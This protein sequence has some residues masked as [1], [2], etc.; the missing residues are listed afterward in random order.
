M[1]TIK[2]NISSPSQ[3]SSTVSNDYNIDPLSIFSK[4]I[5]RMC[6]G[7]VIPGDWILL[8]ALLKCLNNNVFI[9]THYIDLQAKIRAEKS[10]AETSNVL[11]EI[12]SKFLRIGDNSS[13]NIEYIKENAEKLSSSDWLSCICFLYTKSLKQL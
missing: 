10:D 7:N 13:L 9:K 12:S 1:A 4:V 6:T 2:S 3:S 8:F 5:Y 11:L